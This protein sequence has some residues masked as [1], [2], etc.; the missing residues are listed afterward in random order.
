[1]VK[2]IIGKKEKKTVPDYKNSTAKIVKTDPEL[3][4]QC[5][6]TEQQ[7]QQLCKTGARIE[8]LYEYQPQ[9]IEWAIKNNEIFIL[10][11]RPITTIENN[12]RN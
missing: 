5:C 4:N 8:Q 3:R 12:Q 1:M 2:T 9:D 11:T 10:Q 7:I 6:L